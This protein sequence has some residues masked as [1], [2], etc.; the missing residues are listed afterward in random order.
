MPENKQMPPL[1]GKGKIRIVA[2]FIHHG[3]GK[4]TRTLQKNQISVHF[5]EQLPLAERTH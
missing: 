4:R 3:N 5:V 2:L 1:S